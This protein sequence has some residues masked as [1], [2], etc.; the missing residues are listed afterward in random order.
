VANDH[1][2]TID[3]LG[4]SPVPLICTLVLGFTMMLALFANG[5]RRY[6]ALIP[7]AAIN[8][9]SILAACHRRVGE[10]DP[11]RLQKLVFGDVS[12]PDGTADGARHA[13]FTANMT[14]IGNLVKD[15]EY[16]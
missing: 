13:A 12:A 1:D 14:N 9:T 7:L 15:K 10:A 11:I 5:L 16:I 2:K 6:N 4:W 8:S 3:A